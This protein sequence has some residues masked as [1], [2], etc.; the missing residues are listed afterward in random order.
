MGAA[1]AGAMGGLTG[2]A[3]LLCCADEV[4]LPPPPPP[5]ADATIGAGMVFKVDWRS[6]SFFF[7]SAFLEPALAVGDGD[8]GEFGTGMTFPG[9]IPGECGVGTAA[10]GAESSPSARV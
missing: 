9:E 1:A 10:S 5:F 4:G 7:F 6:R 2:A 8:P 3:T